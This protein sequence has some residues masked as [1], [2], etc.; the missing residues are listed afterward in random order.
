MTGISS[1]Q[2][3]CGK[4]PSSNEI[5]TVLGAERLQPDDASPQ[6]PFILLRDLAV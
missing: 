4:G 1:V 5:I 6:L 2:W 3:T